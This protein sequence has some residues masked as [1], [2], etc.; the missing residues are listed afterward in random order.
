MID[1]S[2]MNEIEIDAPKK[3]GQAGAGVRWGEFH[4]AAIEEGLAVAGGTVTTVGVAGFTLGGGSGWLSRKYGLAVDNL[5][6]AEVVTAD[7]EILRASESENPGLFWGIRGGAGNLGIVTQFEFRLHEMAS[8]IL[9]GQILYAFKDAETV[10]RAC[11]ELIPNTPD[12]FTCT[13]CVF[14][15]PPVPAFPEELHGQVVL[16]LVMGH[17]GG[18]E[19]GEAIA[20]RFRGLGDILLEAVGPASYMDLQRSFDA[21][22]PYGQRWYSR[23]HY[24]R[25]LS[26]EAIATFLKHSEDP[27]GPFTLAYLWPEDGA[28]SRVD[29][30]VTA[31]PHR[32]GRFNFHILTGWMGPE[33][34]S[35]AIQWTRTFYDDMTRFST[36]GV[37]VNLLA[38]DESDRVRNAYGSN[39]D[40]LSELKRKWDPENV[41]NSNQNIAP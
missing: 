20:N 14:R 3:R 38:E 32:D 17:L 1:L 12:E 15:I 7:G 37:Y 27:P 23:S 34:D 11:R 13:P 33:Q 4:E 35:E 25:D 24:L 28:I 18:V 8:T 39:F 19:E 36:G 30:S 2:P 10:L 29:S 21:G 40:R 22:V 16:A 6:S 5:L 9:A 31:F 26:D 41:F